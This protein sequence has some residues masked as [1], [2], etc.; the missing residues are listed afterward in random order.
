MSEQTL[1]VIFIGMLAVA[2]FAMGVVVVVLGVRL[3]KILEEIH[4]LVSRVRKTGEA[5]IDDVDELRDKLRAEGNKVRALFDLLVN[6]ASKRFKT[7][8]PR[9]K[10][11]I[12]EE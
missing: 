2:W 11:V 6:F 12:S 10:E 3:L 1:L 4:V 7:R 9:K 5:A 8:A